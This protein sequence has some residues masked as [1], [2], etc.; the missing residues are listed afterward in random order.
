MKPNQMKLAKF[1]PAII[2]VALPAICIWIGWQTGV[3]FGHSNPEYW[4]QGYYRPSPS[5]ALVLGGITGGLWGLV[6]G[7]FLS[8]AGFG[9]ITSWLWRRKYAS[10]QP[11]HWLVLVLAWMFAP[12][13]ICLLT[14]FVLVVL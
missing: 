3:N 9:V 12:M 8:F 11:K 14:T 1:L 13:V 6:A 4:H 10:M 7:S 5:Q 2:F